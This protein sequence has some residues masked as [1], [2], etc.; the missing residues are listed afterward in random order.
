MIRAWSPPVK[1]TPVARD[2][3]VE[4]VGLFRAASSGAAFPFASSVA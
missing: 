2:R 3:R 4:R 1:K